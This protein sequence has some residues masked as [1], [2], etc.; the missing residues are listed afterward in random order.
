MIDFT[1]KSLWEHLQTVKKPIVLYGMGNGADHIITCLEEYGIP[2]Q[3]VFVSDGF[4][5]DKTFHGHKLCSYTD[6]KA[7]LGDMAVLVAFGTNISDVLNN[8]KRIAREQELYAPYVPVIGKGLFTKEYVLGNYSEFSAIYD[9]LADSLSKKTYENILRYRYSGKIEYLTECEVGTSDIFDL[10]SL[11]DDEVYVDLGAYTGDT[12]SDFIAHSPSYKYIYAVEPD[13]K[14]FQKLERNTASLKNIQLFNAAAYSHSNGIAF[15]M[16]SGRNSHIDGKGIL[17]PSV[18]VDDI[19]CG[20]RADFI[21]MDIEGAELCAIDG[22]AATISAYKPKLMISCYHRI[23]DL[24][25]IPHKILS[26]R[27]DYKLYIRHRP[28]IPDWDTEFFFL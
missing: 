25:T 2:L 6:I 10:L 4:V 27:P 1:Q 20:K 5:R 28:Y 17:I 13:R 22:A 15:S 7:R 11:S 16:L 23:D 9:N 8:I 18:S 12:V 3:G 24:F 14:T 21:K 26:L 19:L